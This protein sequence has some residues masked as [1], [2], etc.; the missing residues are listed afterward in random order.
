M[1]AAGDHALKTLSDADRDAL[2]AGLWRDLQD[3]RTPT[4]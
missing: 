4:T 1:N 3:E 2:I